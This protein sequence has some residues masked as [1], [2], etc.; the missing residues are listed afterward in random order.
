MKTKTID[1]VRK[2]MDEG[3]K[4][5][6][7]AKKLKRNVSYIYKLT[8][9][10]NKEHRENIFPLEDGPAWEA[11][12][13]KIDASLRELK[14]TPDLVNQPPHYTVGGIETID[15]IEAKQL[16]YNLGNAVKYISRASHKGNKRQDL[17]KAAWYL[18]REI[19]TL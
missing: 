2:L 10:I 19:E 8:G 9:R 6:E 11:A 5:A 12:F 1:Q 13:D 17:E 16:N 15:F 18:Q 7:I 3:K 4:P 14:A